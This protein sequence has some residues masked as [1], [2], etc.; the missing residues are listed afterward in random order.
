[1]R[2]SDFKGIGISKDLS[3]ERL[4]LF[5]DI[6]LEVFATLVSDAGVVDSERGAAATSSAGIS[7]RAA[8]DAHATAAGRRMDQVRVRAAV[9]VD[10]EGRD[11]V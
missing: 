5:Q 10:L 6:A 2:E 9:I 8:V 3:H 11:A 7:F 4:G 1:M